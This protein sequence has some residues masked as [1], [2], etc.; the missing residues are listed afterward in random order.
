MFDPSILITA[1]LASLL[2]PLIAKL[3]P[4]LGQKLLDFFFAAQLAEM[5]ARFQR[6]LEDHKLGLRRDLET[7]KTALAREM[8]E[9]LEAVKHDYAKKLGD[10]QAERQAEREAQAERRKLVAMVAARV[11]GNVVRTLQALDEAEDGTL[12]SRSADLRRMGVMLGRLD[13]EFDAAC[14][15][16]AQLREH[17]AAFV[18]AFDGSD[19]HDAVARRRIRASLRGIEGL[20]RGAAP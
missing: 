10:Y 16:D 6:Q 19:L 2:L 13:H 1:T 4:S 18:K 9:D 20:L 12:L 15:D 14:F 3:L 8:A 11:H 5:Q 7:H 17:I